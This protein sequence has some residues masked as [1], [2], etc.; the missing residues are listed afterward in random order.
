MVSQFKTHNLGSPSMILPSSKMKSD[1]MPFLPSLEKSKFI[2]KPF[3]KIPNY[4]RFKIFN[5]TSRLEFFNLTQSIIEL[6]NQ[7]FL[8]IDKGKKSRIAYNT[9]KIYLESDDYC[10]NVFKAV[11]NEIHTSIFQKKQEISTEIK[12][13]V[14]EHYDFPAGDLE[15]TIPYYYIIE[16]YIEAQKNDSIFKETYLKENTKLRNDLK[17]KN[18]EVEF[19]KSELSNLKKLYN[20]NLAAY[21][22]EVANNRVNVTKDLMDKKVKELNEIIQQSFEEIDIK[23]SYI[24]MK[25]NLIESKTKELEVLQLEN[26]ELNQKIQQYRLETKK[27]MEYTSI[28][29]SKIKNLKLEYSELEE[30]LRLAENKNYSLS[31]RAAEGYSNLTPRPDFEELEK[32]INGSVKLETTRGK[33][34]WL[35]KS[36]INLSSTRKNSKGSTRKLGK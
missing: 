1:S 6:G 34:E 31:V 33:T 8:N 19:L 14:Y 4:E 17:V 28:L 7:L 20:E 24:K 11:L 29:I 9:L 3:K 13:W 36:F 10:Q 25:D 30:K 23:E 18:T 15:N 32:F 26:L 2:N 5:K 21:E 27:S 12:D 35:I 22:V 16:Y